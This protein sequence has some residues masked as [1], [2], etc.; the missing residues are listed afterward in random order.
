[1]TINFQFAFRRAQTGRFIELCGE[2]LDE[3]YSTYRTQRGPCLFLEGSLS[4]LVNDFFQNPER[5][6]IEN[7]RRDAF[8]DQHIFEQMSDVV[9]IMIGASDLYPFPQQYPDGD[10][11]LLTSIETKDLQQMKRDIQRGVSFKIQSLLEKIER[12]EEEDLRIVKTLGKSSFQSEMKSFFS[13]LPQEIK[14]LPEV[15]KMAI[16]LHPQS[17]S[18]SSDNVRGREH[19]VFSACLKAPEVFAGASEEI[20]ENKV[21]VLKLIQAL[22]E[23]SIF[24][25]PHVSDVLRDDFAIAWKAVNKNPDCY[26]LLSERLKENQDVLF[27]IVKRK[28]SLILEFPEKIFK[29]ERFASIFV[30]LNPACQEFFRKIN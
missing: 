1:M 15:G 12:N 29:N 9:D 11:E 14:D 20:K 8:F 25:L 22:K 6:S 10:G 17:E 18:A 27:F 21:F 28:P 13:T 3:I 7:M 5:F 4:Y 19:L 16:S 2:K 26:H 24:L 23:R 30:K